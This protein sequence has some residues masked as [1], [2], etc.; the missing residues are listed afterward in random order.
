[1]WS[2]GKEYDGDWKDDKKEGYGVF[3]W[4]D[5]RIYEGGYKND[6]KHGFGVFT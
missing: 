3:K 1:M 2:D 4:P 5:G 6:R